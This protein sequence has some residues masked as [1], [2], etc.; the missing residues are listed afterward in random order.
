MRSRC[1]CP[2]PTEPVRVGRYPA[3]VTTPAA[4]TLTVSTVNVN[5]VRAAV[6]KGLLPWLNETGAD[7]VC[8]Q[9]TR[10]D[11]A[12]LHA[13]L[14]PALTAGWHLSSAEPAVKGRNGVA[15]LSRTAPATVR[16][17]FGHPEFDDAGRYLEVDLVG[18]TIA[19]LYLPSGQT[20]T[21]RQ[22][23]KERFMVAFAEHLA[24]LV[25]RPALVCGDWNI[26]HTPDD[27][28]TWKTNQKSSGFL[29]EEREWL[30]GVLAAGWTD[31]QRRL[32]PDGPGPYT[33]WSYRGRA[34]DNDSGWRIDL[35]VASPGLAERATSAVVE[36]AA[37]HALRWSDHAPVTVVYG[38]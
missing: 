9:E 25:G 10:A 4:A 37:E 3:A 23:E 12:Q 24:G 19:S 8:L 22:D 28:K 21:P 32:Q 14:A 17:G 26:A 16:V 6:G 29:P 36:R 35:H 7:V 31:V 5:G 34:F 18:V 27:L 30:G 33:W 11:D 1:R 2:R 38:R 15:V 13:A 20:G